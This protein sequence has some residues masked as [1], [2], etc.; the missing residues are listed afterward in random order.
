MLLKSTGDT[1]TKPISQKLVMAAHINL[2]FALLEQR[3]HIDDG[4]DGARAQTL[5]VRQ[6]DHPLA[7]DKSL[8]SQPS[9]SED[10][11]PPEAKRRRTKAVARCQKTT[12]SV[13]TLWQVQD[14]PLTRTLAMPHRPIGAHYTRSLPQS[15]PIN[16]P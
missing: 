4:A 16:T 13:A 11:L 10:P 14:Q 15:L 9:C 8:V 1:L 2:G 7:A 5:L 12:K 6:P 3:R